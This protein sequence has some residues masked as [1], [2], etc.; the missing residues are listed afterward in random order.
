[1]T[2]CSRCG[3][4]RETGEAR[5][6]CGRPFRDIVNR[7]DRAPTSIWEI[8]FS[9]GGRINRRTFLLKGLLPLYSIPIGFI[10]VMSVV[11]SAPI[12]PD[13]LSFLM[14]A[15][16]WIY[17]LPAAYSFFAIAAKRWH[18]IGNSGW[19]SLM[20]LIPLLNLIAL[21]ML[22]VLG[23]EKGPNRFGMAPE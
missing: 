3:R 1:M 16:L 20:F 22:A 10:V 19:L 12:I 5:C 8:W 2:F 6:E 17:L 21:I 23:G 18:D 4:Q 15:I 9:F 14:A 13:G 11:M 7:L